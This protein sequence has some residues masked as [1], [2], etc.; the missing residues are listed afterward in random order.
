MQ[1]GIRVRYSTI[2]SNVGCSQKDKKMNKTLVIVGAVVVGIAL[3]AGGVFLSQVNAQT[4]Q[5]DDLTG[6]GTDEYGSDMMDNQGGQ[7]SSDMMGN[8]GGQFG[9]DMMDNQGGQFGSDMMGNQGGQ[10]GS[11]MMGNQG[12]QFGSDMMNGGMMGMMMGSGSGMMGNSDA[13]PLSIEDAETAVSDYLSTLDNS[14]LTV[15]EVMIFDNQAYAQILDTETGIGAFE[16]I[17]DPVSRTVYP[18]PGPNMMWNTEFGMASGSFEMMSSGM[19]GM[20]GNM[21]GSDTMDFGSMDSS[22]MGDNAT[23]FGSMD[24]S[25]MGDN[26]TDFGS[27]DGSMMGSNGMDFGSMDGSMMGSNGMDFGSMGSGMMSDEM[28]GGFAVAPGVEISVTADEA[29]EIAQQYLDTYQPGTTVDEA[30]SFPGYYTAHV[31]EDGEI[32]GMLSINGYT[33][34]VF[35]HHWHGDFIEMSTAD[36]S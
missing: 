3:F 11:D 5:P 32:V 16:V 1:N 26:A 22:M 13:D 25:M 14:N 23:D 18:E 20:G 2:I 9:S 21:M 34:Q 8:Q 27:M 10:F 30:D 36:Q 4:E 15:G 24:G 33:G 28:I 6:I 17:V 29:G 35:Y 12:G 31:E 7:Y 19:M